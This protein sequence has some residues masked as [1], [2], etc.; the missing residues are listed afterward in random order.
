MSNKVKVVF[1]RFVGI[2]KISIDDNTIAHINCDEVV[3]T[4]SGNKVIII[5][6]NVAISNIYDC[7]LEIID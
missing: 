2:S 1:Y 6:D 3:K 5:K 7:T 4:F